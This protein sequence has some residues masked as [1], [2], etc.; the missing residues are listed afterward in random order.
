MKRKLLQ[1]A[2][3]VPAMMMLCSGLT[4]CAG[5]S[6]TQS[7][8]ASDSA[9]A[10]VKSDAHV[11]TTIMDSNDGWVKNFSPYVNGAYQFTQGFMFEPLVVFDNYNNNRE[12]M[13]LAEDIVSE[14]DN[15][16]LTVKLR[17]D[18]KWSDGEDF[19]ADDVVFTYM[20]PKDHP[21]IDKAGDWGDEGRL[22]SVT[23]VD[24]YTVQIVMKKPNRFARNS[25]FAQR[26]M[27]PEHVW[28]KIDDPANYVYET[29]K[30]VVTGP[31][32]EVV[33]FTPEMVELGRNPQYWQ[34]DKLQVDVL[35]VPQFNGN[36]AAWALL[37]TGNVDWA[38]IFIPDI[39]KNYVQGDP[40]RKYWYGTNDAVRLAFNYMSPNADNLK[41][42]ENVDFR[43][44]VS[45]A[46]DRKGII[47]S[48]VYG[49][50]TT[51]VPTDT[52]L[53]PA[54]FGYK[55]E[56]AQAEMAKY[57]KYDIEGAKALLAQAGFKDVDNDGFVENPDGSKIKFDI[58]SPA[59]WTDWNDGATICAEGL[60]KIG[61]NASANAQDLS[62]IIDA[63]GTGNFDVLYGGYGSSSDIWR[64]YYDTI[65]DQSRIKTSSWWSICQ[66]NYKN[67]EMTALIEQL[68]EAKDDAAVK[69]ITDQIEEYFANNM[70]NVPI[71]YNGNWFVY[72][73]SRWTGW[74]TEDNMTCQP[75][76]CIHDSKLLQLMQLKPGQVIEA[77]Q[78]RNVFRPKLILRAAVSRPHFP[79]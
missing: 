8:A 79:V 49:Y 30:P 46:V 62:L 76:L 36:D 13:W 69:A 48:A 68:P 31:F 39:E 77:Y 38:H 7:S 58:L 55:D 2:V 71:L 12:T 17:H 1:T 67:D 6:A 72:N 15:K 37:A 11:L 74:S 27:I 19:N 22:E 73:T 64:F 65:G 28:S 40:N 35:R 78:S 20:Y 43:R 51:D 66:T 41:A 75:A 29:D 18:V 44:A 45:M 14:A 4:A 21:E 33:S 34:G 70:I 61:I 60:Q 32:S 26:Y 57:T 3:L 42:F 25:V 47:D 52:G 23:K 5:A 50:L 53:P 10:A 9:A 16:T 24:D 59:G 56:K 54:L 63:W